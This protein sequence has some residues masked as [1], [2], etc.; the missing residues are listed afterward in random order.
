[1]EKQFVT[2]DIA[3]KLKELG[4]NEECLGHYS[5]NGKLHK[6]HYGTC[7]SS[8]QTEFEILAPLWQQILFWLDKNHNCRI[9]ATSEDWSLF[10]EDQSQYYVTSLN[11]TIYEKWEQ[12]ILKAIELINK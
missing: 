4:F 10:Y 2:Y 1:M 3:L 9:Y 5:I 6:L 7:G 11:T 12:A 8:K